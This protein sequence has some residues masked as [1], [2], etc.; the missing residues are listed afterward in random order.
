[1]YVK[2]PK[3]KIERIEIIKTDCKLSLAGVVSR[4][5]PDYV[6]N[7]GLYN[8][9]TGKVNPIPLRIN[10]KT[11]A[12]SS[13]GYWMLA[14][15]KGPDICMIHSS[16]MAKWKYAVACSTML[17]DGVNTIF[18]YTKDQDGVRGRTG[19]GD[20][21]LNVH[22]AVTTDTNGPMRPEKLRTTMKSNKAKNAL[23]LDS[24]GSSQLYALGKYYQAEKR[25]VSYWICIWLKEDK[26]KCPYTEPT[27][28]LKLNSR[29]DGVMW[30]QWHL[31]ITTDGIFGGGTKNAVIAFQKKAFPTDKKQWDGIVGSATRAKL[32]ELKL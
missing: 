6:I 30:I 21:I 3:E 13:D 17:K 9:K 14:W 12:T 28:T 8:M 7:G 23:M 27:K 16:D 22:L 18:T 10:G 29:G 4:Y 5:T 24:G 25:K 1:M 15:N 32:K 11:I 20:D 26:S 31:G 19:F 2:I